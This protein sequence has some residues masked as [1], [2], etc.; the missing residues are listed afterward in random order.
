LPERVNDD[1]QVDIE[2]QL[3][4]EFYEVECDQTPCICLRD[5]DRFRIRCYVVN[6]NELED[7]LCTPNNKPREQVDQLQPEE[8]LLLQLLLL[9]SFLEHGTP[10]E[11]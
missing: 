3:H 2:A 4:N 8:A 7:A 6:D 5:N 9:L 10:D 1:D 11:E